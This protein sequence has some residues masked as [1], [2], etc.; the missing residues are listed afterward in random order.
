MKY[1]VFSSDL[2]N[3]STMLITDMLN[4]AESSARGISNDFPSNV[5]EIYDVETKT[6]VGAFC[7]GRRLAITANVIAIY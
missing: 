5:I 2:F 4:M 1:K 6:C 3:F 7:N